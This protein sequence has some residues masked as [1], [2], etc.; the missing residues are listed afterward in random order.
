LAIGDKAEPQVW[1]ERVLLHGERVFIVTVAAHL[2][3]GLHCNH[4]SPP[5]VP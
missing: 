3:K 5:G 1:V 2:R 4:F